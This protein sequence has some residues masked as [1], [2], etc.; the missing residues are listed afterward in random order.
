MPNS[1]TK[2]TNVQHPTD[3]NVY[4]KEVAVNKNDTL[5]F[6]DDRMIRSLVKTD[7]AL[8]KHKKQNDKYQLYARPKQTLNK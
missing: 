6:R 5:N 3:Q 1:P 7:E 4:E 2:T 8:Q